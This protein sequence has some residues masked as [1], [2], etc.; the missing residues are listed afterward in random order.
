M[1]VQNG[2]WTA[3]GSKATFTFQVQDGM[4]VTAPP[5]G[6]KLLGGRSAAQGIE[7][8]RQSGFELHQP[9]FEEVDA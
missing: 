6:W 4:V 2:W 8:L 3:V 5:Y 1:S 7:F 9:E